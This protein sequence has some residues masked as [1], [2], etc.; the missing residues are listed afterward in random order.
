[1][2]ETQ[3]LLVS[4]GRAEIFLLERKYQN[5]LEAAERLAD[6]QLAGLPGGLWSKYYSIGLAR[7]ALQDEPGA[8]A[9]FLRSK[10]SVED[11]LNRS[12]GVAKLHIQLAK[13]L[14]YLGEKEAALAEAQRATEFQPESR[15]AFE[16][17]AITE[18]AAEVCAIVGENDRAIQ[19]LDG[20]LS[21]PSEVTV[22]GL[23]V[24]PIWDPLRNDPRFRDLLS[25]YDHKA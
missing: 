25:K 15:D 17:P 21:R 8:R 16:G 20:L 10:S 14:A 2:T 22:Q 5:G 4:S 6:D 23:R 19:I 7:R 3:K 18:G 11:D 1:M 24:N 12:P 9:A 13:S